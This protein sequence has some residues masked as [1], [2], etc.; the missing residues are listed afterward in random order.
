MVFLCSILVAGSTFPTIAPIPRL[1]PLD[2]PED[3]GPKAVPNTSNTH[4]AQSGLHKEDLGKLV[5]E[6]R[7]K[8]I[9]RIMR[10]LKEKQ[11]RRKITVKG[12]MEGIFERMV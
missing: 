6:P 12:K 10:R 3:I 7:F 1:H 8:K 11:E 4:N 9:L 2:T 5:Q